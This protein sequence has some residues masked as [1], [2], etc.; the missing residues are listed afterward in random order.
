MER[1]IPLDA[2]DLST[3]S[4]PPLSIPFTLSSLQTLLTVY[5]RVTQQLKE[6]VTD[7]VTNHPITTDGVTSGEPT[8]S[9]AAHEST[10]A[11]SDS[12]GSSLE[13]TQQSATAPVVS[14]ARARLLQ[15]HQTDRSHSGHRGGGR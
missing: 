7:Y 11:P 6:R 4:P 9:A 14:K 8:I 13:I 1:H 5:A 2:T 12:T 15:P 3:T 10:D